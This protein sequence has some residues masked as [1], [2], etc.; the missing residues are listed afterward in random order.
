MVKDVVADAPEDGPPNLA[1]SSC[2]HDDNSTI[3][4]FGYMADIFTR[5]FEVHA[6]FRLNLKQENEVNR[7]IPKRREL[8]CFVLKNL[9]LISIYAFTV[10]RRITVVKIR[11]GGSF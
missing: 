3:L 8:P 2:S 1:H 4:L 6:E 5:L 11:I 9:R 10:E 7:I